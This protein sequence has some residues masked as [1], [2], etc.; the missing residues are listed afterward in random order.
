MR[1]TFLAA[2]LLATAAPTGAQ[3]QQIGDVFDQFFRNTEK[4]NRAFSSEMGGEKVDPFTG[5]L[6]LVRQ[7][8][9]LP[10]KAGLDLRIVRSYSSKIWGRADAALDPLLA[11]KDPSVLGYGWTFHFGRLRNPNASGASTFCSGDFPVFEEPDGTAHVLY[12]IRG[13]NAVFV[14]KDFWRMEKQCAAL[15]GT[16][17]CVWSSSGIRYEMSGSWSDQYF[18]GVEAVWPVTGIV[19]PFENRISVTYLPQT[20]APDTVTDTY[21][22]TVTFSYSNDPSAPGLRLDTMSANANVYTFL[23]ETLPTIAGSRRFLREVLPPAGPPEAYEYAHASPVNE[24][25]YALSRVTYPNGGSTS[26]HYNA[27]YFFTGRQFVPFAVVDQRTEF[28]RAGATIGTW[29]YSYVSPGPGPDLNTT[30][31]TR[32]DGLQ[33]VYSI[34]GFGYVAGLSSGEATFAVGL[35]YSIGRG[36]GAETEYFGWEA[37]PS[38][39]TPR[40]ISDAIYTAPV[41]SDGC[42]GYSGR[43]V[44]DVGVYVPVTT[45]RVLQRGGATYVTE[46]SSFDDY[47]QPWSVTETGYEAA[48]GAPPPPRVR[49]TAWT[50]FAAATD[51]YGRTL[52]MVRGLPL[53]QQ[54]CVSSECFTNSWT[55][56]GPHHAKDSETRSGVATSFG[57]D[58]NGNLSGVTNALGQTLTLSD[59]VYGIP[60]RLDFNGAFAFT[61]TAYWEGLV[62]E[63]WDGR[64]NKTTYVYDAIGRPTLVTP[65]GVNDTTAYAYAPDGSSVTLTRGS[66]NK[67]TQLD[68]FGREVMTSDSEGVLTSTMYDAMGRAW[69]RSYPY[70]VAIGEIG[71]KSE[72]D[73]LGRVLVLTNG[74]R[75]ASNAC[76]TPGACRIT[77]EYHAN[78]AKTSVERATSEVAETWRCSM[79][80]GDP[81]EG[82]LSQVY[83]AAGSPWAYSYTAA[84]ALSSVSAPLAKGNRS[85]TYDSRQYLWTET[86]GETGTITYGRNAVGQMTSK[87]DVRPAS[88]AYGYA[89]PLSRL[90]TVTYADALDDVTRTYE[91]GSNNLWRLSSEN[92]G[93][94][95]YVYDELNR[96]RSQTWSYRDRVYTTTFHYDSVGCLDQIVYPTGSTLSIVCDTAQRPLSVVANSTSVLSDVSYHPSGQTAGLTLG[97]GVRT[98]HTF[99]GKGRTESIV[100]SPALNLHCTYDG[101]D[102]VKS[103]QNVG[104]TWLRTMT[105]DYLDQIWSVSNAEWGPTQ[106]NYDALGNRILSQDGASSVEFTYDGQNRIET[107]TA[108]LTAS[109][110]TFTWDEGSRLVASSDGATYKYDGHDRRVAK[111][112]GVQTT[113]YHY[114]PAGRVIAE[115][116]PDGTRLREYFYLAG[117]LVAVDGCV[118]GAPPSCTPTREWYHTDTLGSVL[119]RTNGAGTVV[120]RFDYK[121]WG[122]RWSTSGATGDRQ[123]NGRVYDPGT[124]FHDYGARMYWPQVGRF[125]S[126]D[127]V[128]GNPANP[129]TLNRYSYVVNNPY[130]YVDPSG[131]DPVESRILENPVSYDYLQRSGLAD[132]VSVGYLSEHGLLRDALAS[133][134]ASLQGMQLSEQNLLAVEQGALEVFPVLVGVGLSTVGLGSGPAT[135]EVAPAG[136]G[137]KPS[138]KFEPPTNPARAPPSEVPAGW[139]V[140]QMG[141]TNQYPNG[142][143]K[144]E[145]PMKDGSWQPIDPSTMK[146]GTRPQTHVPLPPKKPE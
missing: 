118:E 23:Y 35:V 92:G 122:E 86:S 51:V 18:V 66:Y 49:T 69:F 134:G 71:M 85:Y 121:P 102:N 50:Y 4:E 143:W 127:P 28:D 141:A 79:S 136:S 112:D 128:H 107:A 29:S 33:D 111:F 64:N 130:K 46:Y 36:S 119:A 27:V 133:G 140:R 99:D 78:C 34:Y 5:T 126:A 16:G 76:D 109:S 57:Y 2:L 124:G 40:T 32:P 60:C 68:G 14:S 98:D 138:P 117:K 6:G 3:E 21:S 62:H 89:D 1:P 91:L 74:Y 129:A 10:G 12:P 88:V 97:N 82:R 135:G 70:D 7:D 144:L 83:D 100:A 145:K 137:P 61:R 90:R 81:D 20:G 110:M 11:E 13:S 77:T 53:S 24:N 67:T 47:L 132:R 63:Q 146:P 84:G 56:D 87:A 17:A 104:V 142:Y 31:I 131:R 30:T 38:S 65:P 120:A 42:V 75:P 72:F 115:T 15:G 25:Q 59:Y 93:T 58:T 80:F 43:P 48:L 116:L 73:A 105:Y 37:G 106:F 95:E 52:N 55:Y 113:L 19:D 123:Y 103:F 22:R 125:V 96:V 101:A 9:V 8:L 94:Y 45:M 139:R 114:D 39:A 26:Y 108:E 41:Y 54:V 44:W